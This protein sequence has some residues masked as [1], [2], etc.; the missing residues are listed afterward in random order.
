M[1][2]SRMSWACAVVI[3][4]CLVATGMAAKKTAPRIPLRLELA[5]S[6]GYDDNIFRLSLK[7]IHRFQTGTERFPN[8][9]STWDDWRNDLGIT[10]ALPWKHAN[11]WETTLEGSAKAALYAI[12]HRKNFQ[13]YAASLRQTFGKVWW[14]EGSFAII[15]SY[16]IRE[17]LDRDL[18]IRTGCDYE[19]RSYVAK[20]RYRSPWRTY[21][22][23]FYEFQTYY[24][25]RYF[26]E[27]DAEWSTVG[28]A[29]DQ[30]LSRRWTV[31]GSYRFTD[32]N[33]VGGGGLTAASQVTP[34]TLD[35]TEYGDGNF[36][37]NEI[38][39]SIKYKP[40][41]LWKRQ[42][43]FSVSSRIRLRD[44]T[45]DNSVE[46]DPFHAV[47]KD[48]RWEI[49]PR[50]TVDLMQNLTGYMDYLYE[51]RTTDSPIDYVREFKDFVRRT[52]FVGLTYQVLPP[53][54]KRR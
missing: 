19:N 31:S 44:Y 27:F 53:P 37:E 30:I 23:P 25:N 54:R 7:D 50:I 42:W 35:D 36:H 6:S 33:N 1:P 11:G 47:R 15:P 8:P 49:S 24:Y 9:N 5:W 48:T 51:Q 40:R 32:G 3:C 45:T 2:L 10:L 26:T 13:R 43:E 41:R 39:A 46:F 52:Y 14:V 28:L 18:D 29:F 16:Y 12:N 38:R 20:L 21:L 22:Y 4:C 17:Y 34:D